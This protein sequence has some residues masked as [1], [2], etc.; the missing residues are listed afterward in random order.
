MRGKGLE[1]I[2]AQLAGMVTAGS[3]VLLSDWP[4]DAAI[5]AGIFLG[6]VVVFAVTALLRSKPL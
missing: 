6:G 1:R 3:F 5:S 2:A 4:I